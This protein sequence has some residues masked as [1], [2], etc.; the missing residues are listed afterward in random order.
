MLNRPGATTARSNYADV[1]SVT[2][3]NQG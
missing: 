3:Q 2:S 1:N